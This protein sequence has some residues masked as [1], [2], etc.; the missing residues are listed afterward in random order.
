MSEYEPL[1]LPS[2]GIITYAEL[3]KFLK[4]TDE[5]LI[6]S[7]R[8]NKIP[9]LKLGGYRRMWVIRLEDLKGSPLTGTV[10]E[11]DKE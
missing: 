11:E 7:L 9:V 8:K 10:D 3:V 4:T 2:E 5:T 6:T 1:V